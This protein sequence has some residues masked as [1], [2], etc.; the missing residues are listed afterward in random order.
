MVRNT[1]TGHSMAHK[2]KSKGPSKA[3]MLKKL[4]SSVRGSV[5]SSMAHIQE[6]ALPPGVLPLPPPAAEKRVIGRAIELHLSI[7]WMRATTS[8]TLRSA[9]TTSV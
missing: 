6:H 3:K 2:E 5:A 7:V 8:T 1:L 9:S 4:H